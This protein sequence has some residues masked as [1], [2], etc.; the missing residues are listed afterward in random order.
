MSDESKTAAGAGESQ[1]NLDGILGELGSF[2]KYQL[3]LLLLL[4]F[5]D[6]FLAMCNYNYVFTAT[7]VPFRSVIRM[8]LPKHTL[9]YAHGTDTIRMYE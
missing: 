8:S 5:R 1:F 9:L 3:L 4:S 2:G 6:S 7:D